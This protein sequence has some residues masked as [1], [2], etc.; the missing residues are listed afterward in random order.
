MLLAGGARAANEYELNDI[1]ETAYGPL[2]GGTDYT[3]TRETDN[4][5]DWYL[6]YVKTYSQVDFSA[7]MVSYGSGCE[8]S[9]TYFSLYDKDGNYVDANSLDAG[10]I[11]RTEH[12]FLT[13]TPGRY[14]LRIN[15]TS[16]CTGERYRFRI[17]PAAALTTSRECGEAIVAKDAIAPQLA[18]VTAELK[19]NDQALAKATGAKNTAKATLAQLKQ[20]LEATLRRLQRRGLATPVRKRRARRAIVAPKRLAVRKLDAAKEAQGKVLA[21]RT[22]LEALNAQHTTALAQAEGQISATC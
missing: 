20:R 12:L 14:Y 19:E 13:M 22:G 15:E 21:E 9:Y 11:N 10:A 4:D 3:A 1:R 16:Y 17:D 2:A 8:G 7:T 6:F 18:E 5:V